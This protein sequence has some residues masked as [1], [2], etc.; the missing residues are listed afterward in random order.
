MIH[1][2]PSVRP[3]NSCPWVRRLAEDIPYDM[4]FATSFPSNT[5]V[6]VNLRLG[7]SRRNGRVGNTQSF[8]RDVWRHLD[9]SGVLSTPDPRTTPCRI[10]RRS[11]TTHHT[12]PF[13]IFRLNHL[14]YTLMWQK[15]EN[16]VLSL[17]SKQ[18][19]EC[20]ALQWEA[21]LRQRRPEAMAKHNTG[22][23]IKSNKMEWLTA[24]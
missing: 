19:F 4:W 22:R 17:V 8:I 10:K 6:L 11:P 13:D 14:P 3:F 9:R 16:P 7:L 2:Y 1:D 5:S 18:L 21:K 12:N 20:V 15:L 24:F 23:T